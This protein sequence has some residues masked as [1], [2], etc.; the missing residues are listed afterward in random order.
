MATNSP[1]LPA[2][3]KPS[4]P[5]PPKM[6]VDEVVHLVAD[7]N[8]PPIPFRYEHYPEWKSWALAGGLE[9]FAKLHN[10]EVTFV[11]YSMPDKLYKT[12]LDTILKDQDLRN[13]VDAYNRNKA[14]L[15]DAE[16]Y[17][18][19]AMVEGW[20]EDD[21]TS[22]SEEELLCLPKV[23]V[24]MEHE[25]SEA[26]GPSDNVSTLRSDIRWLSSPCKRHVG[27]DLGSPAKRHRR[28]TSWS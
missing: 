24:A 13:A 14:Y 20:D 16:A 28:D 8:K 1:K 10:V 25:A 5:E 2:E 15:T 3:P 23:E 6:T 26:S 22:E 7:K 21:D 12:Y 17:S 18:I 4:P 11:L 19:M 9:E 27:G